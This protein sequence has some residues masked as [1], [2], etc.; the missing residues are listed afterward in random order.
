MI[1]K[2]FEVS[3]GGV[4]TDSLGSLITRIYKVEEKN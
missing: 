3:F 2:F 1:K 4:A